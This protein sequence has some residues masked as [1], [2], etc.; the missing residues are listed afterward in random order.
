MES[1]IQCSIKNTDSDF[2]LD[3][4]LSLPG[5]GVSALFGG[6][7]A[8]KTSILRTIAGLDHYPNASVSVNGEVWQDANSFRPTHKRSLAYVFQEPSLFPHLDVKHNLAFAI[9]RCRREPPRHDYKRILE[10]LNIAHLLSRNVATLSGGEAQ[11]V[12]IARALLADPDLLLMD[13][14]LASLDSAHK[15]EILHYLESMIAEFDL[16]MVYVSHSLTEVAQLADHVAVIERGT[17]QQ[18]GLLTDVLADAQ[19]ASHSQQ[20]CS[21][22][23]AKIVE[24]DTEWHLQKIQFDGGELWLKETV[25]PVGA[26]LRI[27]IQPSDVSIALSRSEDSSIVNIVAANVVTITKGRDVAS[28]IVVLKLGV[29]NV[30]ARVSQKSVA[31]LR[32][33]PGMSVWAQIK[34]VAI[35]G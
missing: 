22:V 14:P 23:S 34:S 20:L 4:S 26:T 6:S 33:A 10:L 27:Q 18:Q 17:V 16:P 28:A 13:E 21:V 32:L 1:L 2:S 30:F 15:T 35:L 25:K 8:G 11:R 29:V 9:R 24:H 3:V 7:G 31:Q 5:K 12:A 19:F